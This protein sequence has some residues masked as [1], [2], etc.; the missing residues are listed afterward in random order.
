MKLVIKEETDKAYNTVARSLDSQN[1]KSAYD[2][3]AVLSSLDID[4]YLDR[5]IKVLSV[6][7]KINDLLYSVQALYFMMYNWNKSF[8]N[9]TFVYP[10]VD[11][12]ESEATTDNTIEIKV[13]DTKSGTGQIY[14]SNK[15]DLLSS[16]NSSINIVYRITELTSGSNIANVVSQ[17]QEKIDKN[18]SRLDIEYSEKLSDI[19][20]IIN[21]TC[22]Y[23]QTQYNVC[24]QDVDGKFYR[25]MYLK[26]LT[27]PIN[28]VPTFPK[29]PKTNGDDFSDLLRKATVSDIERY[30]PIKTNARFD[31]EGN[32][33]IEKLKTSKA[34]YSLVKMNV[35]GLYVVNQ[36]DENGRT[37]VSGMGYGMNNAA[38]KMFFG[39]EG[40][41]NPKV[42]PSRIILTKVN[43]IF[44]YLYI[45]WYS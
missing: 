15:D 28:G 11:E 44:T 17:A 16:T 7:T 35:Y 32:L 21:T 20:D 26:S 40:Y 2:S 41:I 19:I 6:S 29:I 13:D 36:Y 42:N 33:Y 3:I 8:V 27:N 14:F 37:I 45:Y 4:N 34:L 12:I 5:I 10:E 22:L 43:S 9:S 25:L 38:S 18:P 23:I 39:F 24:R 31:F 30:I 1:L